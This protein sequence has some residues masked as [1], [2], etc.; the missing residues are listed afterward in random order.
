MA[1]QR[2]DAGVNKGFGNTIQ[3]RYIAEGSIVELPDSRTGYLVHKTSNK[4]PWVIV[5]PGQLAVEI[6]RTTPLNVLYTPLQLAND[7]MKT[8][9]P[10]ISSPQTS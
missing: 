2:R 3:A 10:N 9:D 6:N 1:I 7:W 4:K 5:N 8:N